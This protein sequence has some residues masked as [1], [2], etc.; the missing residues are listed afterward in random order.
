MTLRS[1]PAVFGPEGTTSDIEP[2]SSPGTIG[3][4]HR[5]RWR[6]KQSEGRCSRCEIRS[7]GVCGRA[8]SLGRR[9]LDGSGASKDRDVQQAVAESLRGWRCAC[10]TVRPCVSAEYSPARVDEPAPSQPRAASTAGGPGQTREGA[11]QKWG[12]TSSRAK[13]ADQLNFSFDST[14]RS[15]VERVSGSE[16][17]MN[18]HL[19]C[20]LT[21][22]SRRIQTPEDL[23][24]RF[25]LG[26]PVSAK[27]R[28]TRTPLDTR[29]RLA[30]RPVQSF[31][32]SSFSHRAPHRL[33]PS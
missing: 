2:R 24:E 18:S 12:R 32:F 26:E 3:V 19:P 22:E 8:V 9:C 25:S 4:R 28:D 1:C 16:E 30:S 7:G 6:A 33:C 13:T 21:G 11:A 15:H 20:G 5:R 10:A 31:S 23:S 14:T 17:S 27:K 29:M